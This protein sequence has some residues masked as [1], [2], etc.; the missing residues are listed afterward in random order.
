M[1]PSIAALPGLL[2][3]AGLH[4]LAMVPEIGEVRGFLGP[5]V[6]PEP[7]TH[8]YEVSYRYGGISMLDDLPSTA[9]RLDLRP[10]S[11]VDR[12]RRWVAEQIGVDV[13][14]GLWF[15][16]D[17]HHWY[18]EGPGDDETSRRWD[19]GGVPALLGVT[20]PLVALVAIAEHL[21]VKG[22]TA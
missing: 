17:G 14:G 18:L 11:S 22:R 21:A 5:A 20:E 7:V 3:E 10:P 15:H 2:D 1:I 8:T 4:V 13:S 6:G 19:S 16:G 9:I 12:L